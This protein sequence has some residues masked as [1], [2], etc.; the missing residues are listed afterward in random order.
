[1]E[2]NSVKNKTILITGASK[3]VGAACA[4][5]FASTYSQG[6]N[7]ALVA[8][9]L[10]PLERLQEELREYTQCRTVLIV[11]DMANLEECDWAVSQTIDA[12]SQAS[13]DVLVNN[14]GLHVRGEFITRRAQDISAMIDVNL[15]APLYLS[16]LVL[17]YMH[18]NNQ[19]PCAIVNVGSLAGMTPL[20]GAATYSATKAGLRAFSYALHDELADHNINV[21]VVSPGPIDTGFIMQEMD[22]VEDIVYSQPMSSATQVA[23]AIVQLSMSKRYEIA[24]PK[25]SGLLATLGYLSSRFRRSVR[26]TLYRIGKKNKEKYR[27]RCD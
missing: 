23:A 6:V 7:L 21:A 14:A 16:A 25:M 22:Q 17:P 12:F 20:Q 24:M 15:R 10:D 4:H 19:A 27:Q 9:N 2:I 8:R 5:A 18:R 13:I 3:G 26:G 1:M 11:A